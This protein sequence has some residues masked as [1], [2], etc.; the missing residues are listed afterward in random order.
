MLIKASKS[1]PFGIAIIPAALSLVGLSLASGTQ[2]AP[3]YFSPGPNQTYGSVTQSQRIASGSHNPASP[4][5]SHNGRA[6]TG[7]GDLAVRSSA[8]LA[9][10]VG[11]EY[12]SVNDLFGLIDRTSD[13]LDSPSSG[14]STGGSTGGSGST[15]DS[16]DAT[17][18]K[19]ALKTLISNNPDVESAFTAV[20][21]KVAT[22]GGSL[23]LIASKGYGKAFA[24]VDAPI[25]VNTETLGGVV[26]FNA[27]VAA[28]SKVAGIADP[29]QLDLDNLRSQLEAVTQ[30]SA[31]SGLTEFQLGKNTV[32]RVDPSNQDIDLDFNNDSLLITKAA[33]LEEYS[34]GYSRSIYEADS[35]ELYLGL[36]P[37][38]LRAGLTRVGV[39]FGDITDSESLFDDIK[40]A[41]FRYSERFSMDIGA[42]WVSDH[43]Q[44][45]ASVVNINQPRFSFP[46]I[47]TGNISNPEIL[48]RIQ[49][50][51]TYEMSRQ[52]K[53]E[54]G[55]FTKDRTWT[56]NMALDANAAPDPMGDDYQW[57]SV[58]GGYASDSWWLPGVRT[59]L[60]HNL[61][62]TELSYL[63]AGVTLF[64]Y[65]DVDVSTALETVE[66]DGEDLPRGLNLSIGLGVEF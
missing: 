57:V 60:H 64:K 8:M 36:K 26:Q 12:G 37:K 39:R 47:D 34:V 42:L 2:A 29:I 22:L 59:G 33:K 27:S 50:D 25:S 9:V 19:D 16:P 44:A 7:D 43:Y 17:P 20:V 35:G 51:A 4:I 62:G 55:V 13:S 65:L 38:Y 6:G 61:A 66:I 54:G 11:I 18:L 3:F 15:P 41:E 10:G 21:D 53:L 63:S 30:L 31:S 5:A 14:G 48:R 46:A 40:N 52:F 56:L 28:T 1:G 23:L 45:G 32:L 58:S 24:T 49:E